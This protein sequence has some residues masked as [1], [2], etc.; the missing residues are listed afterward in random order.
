[1]AFVSSIP[2]LTSTTITSSAAAT[3]PLS[4][5]TFL[6][7]TSYRSIKPAF[8]PVT[9]KMTMQETDLSSPMDMDAADD[10]LGGMESQTEPEVE[11]IPED[12][13]LFVGNLSWTTTDATL[14][15]AF[16][17]HGD[18]IDAR[19]ITDKFTGKSRGF[20]FIE[21]ENGSSAN[22]ALSKMDGVEIDGRPVRVDRANR[23]AGGPQQRRRF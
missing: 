12:A 21:Y 17:A 9:V 5:S 3:T 16:E 4:N 15:A 6:Q 20:G 2:L 8:M 22:D 18:V 19:V 13:K 1:M 10:D 23:K 7:S 14:G 11:R